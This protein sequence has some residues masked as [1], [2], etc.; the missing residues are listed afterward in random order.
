VVD[1]FHETAYI[2]VLYLAVIA[3]CLLAARHLIL[4]GDRRSWLLAGGVAGDG[5]GLR[6]QPDD[7]AAGVDRRHR[8][9]GRA[10]RHG[11]P[12]SWRA[13]SSC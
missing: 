9:L 7:R 8:Q 2:G 13:R 3:A 6:R 12:C 11:P 4:V 5:A 10:P 1:Q